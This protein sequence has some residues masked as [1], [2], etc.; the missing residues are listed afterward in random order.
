[1]IYLFNFTSPARFL[2]KI[3]RVHCI[4]WGW[5]SAAAA[6]FLHIIYHFHSVVLLT[7]TKYYYSDSNKGNVISVTDHTFPSRIGNQWL[8]PKKR[9]HTEKLV[10][11]INFSTRNKISSTTKNL[12]EVNLCSAR[13]LSS[14]TK[15]DYEYQ[16]F[17]VWILSKSEFFII[18]GKIL[19]K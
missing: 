3:C 12:L 1:M 9:I 14:C 17:S 15:I 5:E 18:T 13:N 19:R 16:Y 10:I 4:T 11:I 7:S 6:S 2:C 8:E